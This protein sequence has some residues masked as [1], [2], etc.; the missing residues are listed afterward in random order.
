[1]VHL[2]AGKNEGGTVALIG[3]LSILLVR[4]SSKL[5]SNS[6]CSPE[7]LELLLLL[8][9]APE[10]C[11]Y[12]YVSMVTVEVVLGIK[13]RALCMVGKLPVNGFLLTK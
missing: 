8:P 3:E 13:P 1:M 4:V 6:L 5:T 7:Y 11:D 10:C 2:E 12:R 9:L